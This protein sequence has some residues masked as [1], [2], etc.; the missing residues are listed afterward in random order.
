MFLYVCVNLVIYL[1]DLESIHVL[2]L[3][4][5]TRIFAC[6]LHMGFGIKVNKQH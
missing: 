4:F 5:C 3:A 2:L 1:L 6:L